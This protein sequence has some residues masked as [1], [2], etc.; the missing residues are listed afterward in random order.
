MSVQ[1][2]FKKK[3]YLGLVEKLNG[4]KNAMKMWQNYQ[5]HWIFRVQLN[6]LCG[7]WNKIE[8]KKLWQICYCMWKDFMMGWIL[9]L[10]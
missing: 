4:G 9:I 8:F 1:L 7:N 10:G 2:I 6:L 3:H 5:Q